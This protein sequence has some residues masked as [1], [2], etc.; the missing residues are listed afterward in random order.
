M[1]TPTLSET[2]IACIGASV[3]LLSKRNRRIGQHAP[4]AALCCLFTYG[5]LPYAHI[6][7]AVLFFLFAKKS[8]RMQ[9]LE[10]ASAVLCFILFHVIA[11]DRCHTH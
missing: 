7:H 5:H 10:I 3:P 8:I 11:L 9:N 2:G 4:G 1:G 6:N